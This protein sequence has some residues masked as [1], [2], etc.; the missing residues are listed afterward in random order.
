MLLAASLSARA[1]NIETFNATGTFTDNTS[2]SGTL[3]IDTTIGD[4]E[5]GDFSYMGITYDV[6]RNPGQGN[7]EYNFAL[8]TS[9]GNLPAF[10]FA[11]PGD[12]IVGFDGGPFC[13]L[14]NECRGGAGGYFDANGNLTYLQTGTLTPAATPEPSSVALLGTGLLG[15]LGVMRRRLS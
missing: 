3:V 5:S 1:D 10:T 8:V 4:V 13:S 7:G 2:F 6:L 14:D 9:A 11:I 15:F 12:S